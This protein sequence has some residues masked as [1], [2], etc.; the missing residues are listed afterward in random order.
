MVCR[1]F[2]LEKVDTSGSSEFLS[3]ALPRTYTI[4]VFSLSP[5]SCH[6]ARPCPY[7]SENPWDRR[8][9]RSDSTGHCCTPTFCA[10][11]RMFDVYLLVSQYIVMS[12]GLMSQDSESLLRS[13]AWSSFASLA[14]E[15]DGFAVCWTTWLYHRHRLASSNHFPFQ[16]FSVTSQQSQFE[17]H[18]NQMLTSLTTV[19]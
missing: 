6:P 9:A 18:P 10:C 2:F 12:T 5:C 16:H 11:C 14:P 4:H 1:F 13:G 7:R 17:C 19:L 3:T 8:R 15:C